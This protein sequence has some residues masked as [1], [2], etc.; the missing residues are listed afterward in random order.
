MS[1]AGIHTIPTPRL[2]Y[3]TNIKYNCPQCGDG[4]PIYQ[5]WR[6]VITFHYVDTIDEDGFAEMT[7][8]AEAEFRKSHRD[9]F[10]CAS[11]FSFITNDL[12]SYMRDEPE[13]FTWEEHE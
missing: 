13:L 10:Y 1:G 8:I 6:K 5:A 7:E 9:G 2:M 12:N 4:Q 3:L 11:C